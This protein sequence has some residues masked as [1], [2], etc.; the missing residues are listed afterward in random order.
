M[1]FG[2]LSFSHTP[3]SPTIIGALF[4]RGAQSSSRELYLYMGPG[5]WAVQVT[6]PVA[7]PGPVTL[8][9]CDCH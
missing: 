2:G 3:L 5:L 7:V 8:T 1:V 9:V 6:V 4:I